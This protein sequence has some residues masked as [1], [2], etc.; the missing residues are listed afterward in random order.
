MNKKFLITLGKISEYC[1]YGFLFAVLFIVLSP[2]LPTK[3]ILLSYI[4]P[5][6]SMTPKIPIGSV[7]FV[8]PA[9]KNPQIGDIIAF[10]SPQDK[11]VTILHQVVESNSEGFITKGDSNTTQDKWVVPTSSIKG[12]YVGGIPYFGHIA[13]F[14]KKPIGFLLLAV[15]P[16]LLLMCISLIEIKEGIEEEL[17]KRKQRKVKISMISFALLAF[18]IGFSISHTEVRTAFAAWTAQASIN[19]MTISAQSVPTPTATISPSPSSTPMATSNPL[20]T[21]NC[22]DM[23]IVIEG[24]GA[25]SNNS[26]DISCTHTSI[27]IQFNNVL[28]VSSVGFK[29]TYDSEQGFQGVT[30]TIP[31]DGQTVLLHDIYLGSCSSVGCI[32]HTKVAHK[33]LK[34]IINHS[35]E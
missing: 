7:V 3:N 6:G 18:S 35:L 25:G 11:T 32:N 22:S 28:G 34:L 17:V 14:V 8:S 15:I 5:T 19:N 33:F 30:G 9:R 13:A 21:S 2:K 27:V 24:N 12:T 31:F 4:V 20:P 29:S 1:I 16:A 10:A 26:I 23:N